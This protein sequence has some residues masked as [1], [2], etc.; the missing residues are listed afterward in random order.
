MSA[1]DAVNVYVASLCPTAIITL[2]GFQIL[3][4]G[5]II[6]QDSWLAHGSKK[7]T[8]I[9]ATADTTALQSLLFWDRDLLL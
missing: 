4:P 1:I 8:G 5:F 7:Y 6:Q 2:V 3:F 9:R